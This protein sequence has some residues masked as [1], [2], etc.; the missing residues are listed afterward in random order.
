MKANIKPLASS[1]KDGGEEVLGLVEVSMLW[2]VLK[3]Q[4]QPN[5]V[6]S[7]QPS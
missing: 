1:T 2:Q 3:P 4:G 7:D 5:D 6:S